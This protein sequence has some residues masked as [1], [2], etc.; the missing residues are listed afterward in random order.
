MRFFCTALFLPLLCAATILPE[1]IGPYQR[2]APAKP[3]LADRPI[4]DE[5]GLKNWESAVYTNG[6]SRF[7]ATVWQLQDTT[8]ALAAFEWQ[9]LAKA[10]ASDAAKLAAQTDDALLLAHGNYLLSFAGYKP[11]KEELDTVRSAL[12]NVDTTVLPV[13]ASYLP[14]D[15]LVPNSE[16]YILGPTSLQKFDPVISP[17]VAAFHFGTEAQLGVFHSVKGDL[18]VAIFNYPTHQIAMQRVAE[19]EKVPGAMVK[20]SGPLVAVTVAPPDP[21]FAERVLGQVRYQAEITQTE[22]VPTKHDNIGYIV[23]SAFLLIAILLAFSLVSGFA[24]GA[25]KTIL[26]RGRQGEEAD[27][28]TTL[29]LGK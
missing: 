15:G 11:S 17:S 16:R 21:D 19:F 6:K 10:T 27:P 2:G 8:D 12:V 5:Y 26:R 9:R 18:T 24:F 23:L 28:L 20:R 7:T 25:I 13:L 1:S 4:W 22:Y 29:H 3:A 14:G